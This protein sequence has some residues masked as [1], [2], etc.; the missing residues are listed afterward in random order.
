MNTVREEKYK[1][2][3]SAKEM[4]EKAIVE[5]TELAQQCD[6]LKAGYASITNEC[7]Q[8]YKLN[9]DLNNQVMQLAASNEELAEKVKNAKEE[10]ECEKKRGLEVQALVEAEKETNERLKQELN[11]RTTS[12]NAQVSLSLFG[13]S[14]FFILSMK[15]NISTI[16]T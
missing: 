11:D 15:T 2:E 12:L 1:V 3:T 5:K 13:F 16:L 6:E 9:E 7:S 14:L 4:L 10:L 8:V